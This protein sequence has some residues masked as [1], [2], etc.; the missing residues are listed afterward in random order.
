MSGCSHVCAPADSALLTLGDQQ[1]PVAVVSSWNWVTQRQRRPQG[2]LVMTRSTTCRP[3]LSATFPD[4]PTGL[5]MLRS[6][7]RSWPSRPE[8]E[9]LASCKK[10]RPAGNELVFALE[11][12]GHAMP[13]AHQGE[14]GLSHATT[15]ANP[16][17]TMLSEKPQACGNTEGKQPR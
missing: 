8:R 12:W 11:T 14:G 2:Q 4:L 5:P 7:G 3:P 13:L 6:V 17:D 9:K 15:Q 10:M 16:R 1:V